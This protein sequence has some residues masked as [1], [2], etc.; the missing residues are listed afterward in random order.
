MKNII[1]VTFI[2]AFIFVGCKKELDHP[3]INTLN[4]ENIVNLKDVIDLYSNE[5][6]KITDSLSVYA[7]V[8][9]DQTEGNI[10]KNLYIQD[11]TGAINMRMTSS[12]DFFVGDYIRI[13]LLGSVVSN[14]NGVMQLDSIDPDTKII[15]QA[16]N[17]FIIPEIVSINEIDTLKVNQLIMLENVQFSLSDINTTYA[18]AG[19]QNAKNVFIEDCYGHSMILR[20]SDFA[21]YAGQLIPEGQGSIV[22]IV[23]RYNDD[24]QLKIR[25]LN[26]IQMTNMRCEGITIAAGDTLF[27]NFDDESISSGGWSISQVIGT[28][29]WET[30]T[31]G[32][33]P[34]PYLKLSNYDFDNSVNNDCESWFISPKLNFET[35]TSPFINFEN[36]VNYSGP[37]LQMLISTDYDGVSDPNSSTWIDMTSDVSW[38]PN[39]GGWGFS[40]T[41][42]TDLSAYS[43]Q[44]IFIAFKYTGTT[45]NGSTWELDDIIISG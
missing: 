14:F 27:K 34:D 40:N 13:N 16:I 12:G 19:T 3:P 21:S 31:A 23:D 10:Y 9:M 6:V 41:G 22:A 37:A 5:S 45:S 11:S 43:G 44:T 29:T 38:D 20:T 24:L 36:D 42:D 18:D 28:D 2:A 17:Q 15:R 35:G 25:F 32:G 8:T 1:Y 30:S 26:E 7:T 4:K 33:A 39:T